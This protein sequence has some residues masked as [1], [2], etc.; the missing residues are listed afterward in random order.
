MVEYKCN[1]CNKIFNRK[2]VYDKHNQ[3]KRSCINININDNLKQTIAP[4]STKV[5]INAPKKINNSSNK[6]I[7]NEILQTIIDHI[8]NKNDIEIVKDNKKCKYCGSTFTRNSSLQR[9]INNSCDIKIKDDI[10]LKKL[11]ES[12]NKI[13]ELFDKQK[14]LELSLVNLNDKKITIRKNNNTNNS[15]NNINTNSNNTINN[16]VNNI[17]ICGIGAEDI[18]KLSAK[19]LRSMYVCDNEQLFLNSIKGINFNPDLPQNHNIS[20]RNLRSNDCQVYDDNKWS[21]MDIKED[22]QNNYQFFKTDNYLSLE[23][24]F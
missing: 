7:K 24:D 21:T 12:N 6:I 22:A 23:P 13:I 20:Y 19:V 5:H 9:H 16:N 10:I 15:N 8:N 14:N 4:K 18:S 2:S 17:N 1:L 11:E 3:R